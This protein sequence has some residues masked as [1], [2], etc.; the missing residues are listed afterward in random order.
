MA[1]N[2]L[3]LV[4]LI[5]MVLVTPLRKLAAIWQRNCMGGCCTRWI[6]APAKAARRR[7]LSLERF[8]LFNLFNCLSSARFGGAFLFLSLPVVCRGLFCSRSWTYYVG[9]AFDSKCGHA[10]MHPSFSLIRLSPFFS[11]LV[12]R[13]KKIG[14]ILRE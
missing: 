9:S 10:S 6:V 13:K 11:L 14:A 8:C 12:G 1:P 5:A 2:I 3:R 4:T 7:C